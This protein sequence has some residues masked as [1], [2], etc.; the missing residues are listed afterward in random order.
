MLPK[1]QTAQ[2]VDRARPAAHPDRE[3]DGLRGRP[4]R[5]RGADRERPRA[6]RTSTR[7]RRPRRASRRSSSAR[8]TSW[9]RINMKSLVVGEQ[10]PGYDVGDAYHHILMPI[11]MAARAN[12][13]QAIDGPYLQ[14]RDVD[15]FRRVAGRSAALGFDGKWALHP[16]QI[17]AANEVYSPAPGGLRPRRADP[18]RLRVV[19]LRGRRRAGRGDARRRDD[20]RGLPQDGA[21][22]RG[23][24]PRRRHEPDGVVHATRAWPDSASGP[25]LRCDTPGRVKTGSRT[26]R[27]TK[28]PMVC[29]DLVGR[30]G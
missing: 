21:G 22:D 14:I 8:P 15:G 12:D 6:D 4:D 11:L 16:G 9:P 18:R 26:R 20:R 25:A 24:G 10:P 17:D 13:M 5:H 28:V 1:V 3:D 29:L 30:I 2:Q 27:T 7:S 23:Q 19:H